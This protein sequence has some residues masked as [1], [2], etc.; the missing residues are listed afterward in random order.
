MQ[1]TTHASPTAS[2]SRMSD[3]DGPVPGITRRPMHLSITVLPVLRALSFALFLTPVL[4]GCGGGV[5]EI[6][7][8]PVTPVDTTKPGTPVVQRGALTVSVGIDAADAGLA[9]TAGV[10]R[11]GLTVLLR[12][13]ASAD[14][15]RIAITNTTGV[16]Q[17]DSLLEGQY[18]ISV[19]RRLSAAEVAQLAPADREVGILAA[20]A[21]VSF[22]PPS[23]QATLELVASRRGSLVLSEIMA[24]QGDESVLAYPWATYYEV[25]N[26]ADTTIFLDG[27][28]LGTTWGGMHYGFPPTS[29]CE[30][31]NLQA[32]TDNAFLRLSIVF[33]FPGTGRQYAIPPG[34]TRVIA[35]DAINHTT[36]GID[37][38][39]AQFEQ[40]GSDA[41]TDNPFSE[42]MVRL[43]GSTGALGRGWPASFQQSVALLLPSAASQLQ[44]DSIP[45]GNGLTHVVYRAPASL[46]LD[47]LSLDFPAANYAFIGTLPCRPFIG[48]AFDR[49]PS[50]L[51]Y[52]PAP[53]AHTRKSLGRTAAGLEILQRT[54]N[55]LR[56][57]QEAQ[58]LRRSLNR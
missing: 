5:S 30:S 17:F 15:P 38:S 3:A 52:L 55:S 47:V 12:R 18:E 41:D 32:R 6:G 57:L 58:P 11:A 44:R 1:H 37:L 10:T 51:R 46:V 42:N 36:V 49:E 20:G 16:A 13:S 28:L 19:D 50:T 40:V 34:E 53:R 4:S 23:R 25:Y 45:L 26:A 31:P 54:R 39:K 29:T 7:P 43:I 21:V 35:Q 9:S 22:A 27:I 33:A 2:G 24:W 8:G 56:D 14:V 48:T